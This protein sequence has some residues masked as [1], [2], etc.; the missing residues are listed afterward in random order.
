MILDGGTD[1]PGWSCSSFRRSGPIAFECSNDQMLPLLT[2]NE[3]G[4]MRRSSLHIDHLV[5]HGA[6]HNVANQRSGYH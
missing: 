5:D 3:L 4:T 6:S 2:V 1:S